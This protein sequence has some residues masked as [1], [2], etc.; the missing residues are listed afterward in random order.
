MLDPASRVGLFTDRMRELCRE[1]DLPEFD[2]AIYD[3]PLETLAFQWEHPPF[4][5]A[6][7]LRKSSVYQGCDAD[8]LRD[9]W[10][11]KH[12]GDWRARL[13]RGAIRRKPA[14]E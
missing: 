4:G 13:E 11:R 8:R 1:A 6:V 7:S 5:V 9:Q 2:R 12:G 14:G 3:A 10:V